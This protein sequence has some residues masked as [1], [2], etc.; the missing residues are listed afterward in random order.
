M[1]MIKH[2]FKKVSSAYK[3]AKVLPT[4]T[5][6]MLILMFDLQTPPHHTQDMTHGPLS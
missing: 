2:I 4:E 6:N 1:S 3:I 5:Q